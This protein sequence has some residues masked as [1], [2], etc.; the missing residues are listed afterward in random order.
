MAVF[1][2]MDEES[3]DRAVLPADEPTVVAFWAAWCPHCRRFRPLFERE[4]ADRGG[5]FAIVRLDADDNPLWERYAVAVVPTVALFHRG[6][7]A[8]RKD[9]MLGR[10]I[11]GHDLAAFL[12]DALPARTRD[13]KSVL[14]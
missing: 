4:S 14:G 10:G 7:V 5:R 6:E 1:E 12:D 8:A 2:V 11:S 13:S 3:F 9:G